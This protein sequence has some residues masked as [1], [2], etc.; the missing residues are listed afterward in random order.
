MKNLAGFF[1]RLIPRSRLKFKFIL[2]AT[3]ATDLVINTDFFQRQRN[4]WNDIGKISKVKKHI[5]SSN[6]HINRRTTAL[7][8]FAG[9]SF[10][11]P[12][13]QSDNNQT[14]SAAKNKNPSAHFAD[15][16]RRRKSKIGKQ[17]DEKNTQLKS[18]IFI[19]LAK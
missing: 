10:N 6:A 1:K 15:K 5:N 11:K 2:V 14:N 7:E 4:R 3:D 16:Y 18:E 19:S 8:T 13:N 12:N 9:K 17:N